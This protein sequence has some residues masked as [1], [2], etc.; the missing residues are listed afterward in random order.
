M[1]SFDLDVLRNL[2]LM[3]LDDAREVSIDIIKSSK[4]KPV[5]MNRLV[6]DI[7]K[8][9]TSRE[10]MRIMWATYMSGTGFGTIGSKW[11]K[12]YSGI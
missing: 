4:T 7:T 3:P 2:E 10:V 1:A 6:Y 11:K 8:A 12:H 5:V 9:L